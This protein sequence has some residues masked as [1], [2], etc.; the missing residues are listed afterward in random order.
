MYGIIRNGEP[1][2]SKPVVVEPTPEPEAVVKSKPTMDECLESLRQ[3][4]DA[5]SEHALTLGIPSKNDG[6]TFVAHLFC[7]SYDCWVKSYS[8]R[9]RTFFGFCSF[10]GPNDMCAEY[11]Y[12]SI[13]E[14][15]AM[16]PYKVERDLYWDPCTLDELQNPDTKSIEKAAK[17][18]AEVIKDEAVTHVP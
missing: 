6:D 15:L 13:D 7:S 14:L 5:T 8:K 10:G 2:R 4:P 11:G 12:V 3:I 18:L 16:K 17:Q 9:D 1:V